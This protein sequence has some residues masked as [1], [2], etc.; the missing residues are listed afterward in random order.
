MS[1]SP[2]ETIARAAMA[3][4]QRGGWLVEIAAWLESW[5]EVEIALDGPYLE[6]LKH[7]LKIAQAYL[8][9]EDA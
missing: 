5:A 1:E 8:G 4:R 6:D 7:A 9:S 2:A 3:M